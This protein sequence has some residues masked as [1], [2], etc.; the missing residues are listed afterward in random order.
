MSLHGFYHMGGGG[1]KHLVWDQFMCATCTCTIKT[2]IKVLHN[3]TVTSKAV[4]CIEVGNNF[5]GNILVPMKTT[6][7]KTCMS[8]QTNSIFSMLAVMVWSS[9]LS[10]EGKL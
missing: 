7:L 8:H 10:A 1:K 4:A 9:I 6:H 3:V 2:Q 5:N